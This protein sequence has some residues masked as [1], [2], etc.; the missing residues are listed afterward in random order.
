MQLH[1]SEAFSLEKLSPVLCCVAL[2]FFLSEW[3][4]IHLHTF[5]L[6]TE[7]VRVC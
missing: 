4:S 1:V 5:M 3:L 7:R 6:T 2:F